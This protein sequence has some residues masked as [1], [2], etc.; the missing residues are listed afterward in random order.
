MRFS[1]ENCIFK[2]VSRKF[3]GSVGYVGYVGYMSVTGV[4]A[5]TLDVSYDRYI[6]V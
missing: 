4:M 6:T 5:V 3:V 1:V 2:V